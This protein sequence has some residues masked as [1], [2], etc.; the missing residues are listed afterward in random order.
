MCACACT[1]HTTTP[2]SLA[3][4]LFLLRSVFPLSPIL[5]ECIQR[6]LP[7]LSLP[8]S[9]FS[10]SHSQPSPHFFSTR[11]PNPCAPVSVPIISSDGMGPNTPSP[12][13]AQPQSSP[14]AAMMSLD[15]SF[16]PSPFANAGLALFQY[17]VVHSHAP[18][19]YVHQY[20]ARLLSNVLPSK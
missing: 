1:T 17:L 9:L 16:V 10:T 15:H 3:I 14:R 5:G 8:A 4:T 6:P 20:S 19:R 7:P 11:A 18:L 12:P 2:C 13:S